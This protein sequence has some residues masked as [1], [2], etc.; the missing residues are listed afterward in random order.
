MFSRPVDPNGS[1][2]IFLP[3]VSF[4]GH[5]RRKRDKACLWHGARNIWTSS[6]ANLGIESTPGLGNTSRASSDANRVQFTAF[7]KSALQPM[8]ASSSWIGAQTK[9]LS[10]S[11]PEAC[12]W[13]SR[14][15]KSGSRVETHPKRK[16]RRSEIVG[17]N[18]NE[19]HAEVTS[20]RYP[21]QC[22][23]LGLKIRCPARS[24]ASAPSL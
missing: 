10:S 17:A 22:W 6:K 5:Y 15:S 11:A 4:G 13:A 7:R 1:F 16:V 23:R 19:D 2:H 3:F 14:P 9:L 18:E 21:P 20:K 24:F 8:L 12:W